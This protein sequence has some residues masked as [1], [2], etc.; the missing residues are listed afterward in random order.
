MGASRQTDAGG[1][2]AIGLRLGLACRLKRVAIFQNRSS[3]FRSLFLRMSL[4]QKRASRFARQKR[5][6]LCLGKPLHTFAR[7]ALASCDFQP[8]APNQLFIASRRPSCV[9]SPTQAT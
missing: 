2:D 4:R 6:A 5:F 7:H 9:P 8:G 3:P 1:R